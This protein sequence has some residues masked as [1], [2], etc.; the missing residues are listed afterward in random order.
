[1][2]LL[3]L[4]KLIGR[5]LGIS[6]ALRGRFE[7]AGKLRENPHTLN[8]SFQSVLIN[9]RVE[10]LNMHGCLVP[11]RHYCGTS[12]ATCRYDR[13]FGNLRNQGVVYG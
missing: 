12:K 1:M 13:I 8:E 11:T 7:G 5:L 4:R 10:K 9:V 6:G 3:R 2:A